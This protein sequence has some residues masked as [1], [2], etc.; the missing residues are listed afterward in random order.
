MSKK[1]TPGSVYKQTL[2]FIHGWGM[3]KGIWNPL[4]KQIP[5]GFDII[6]LSLPGYAETP[7][8]R[9]VYSIESIAQQL[10]EVLKNK[11]NMIVIGWSLGGL[12]SI[13]MAEILGEKIKSLIL[14]ASSPCFV[15]RKGWQLAVSEQVFKDF[16]TL[17]IDNID[18]TISRFIAIQLLG[19]DISKESRKMM[20]SSVKAYP[21]PEITILI[22]GLDILL[23]TD[24]REKLINLKQTIS[25]IGGSHDTLVPKAALSLLSEQ[26]S[27]QLYLI[28]KAGHAPFVS[29]QQQFLSSLLEVV[30]AC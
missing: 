11:N 2:V 5:K 15:Q 26:C 23:S 7:F 28:D 25:F 29:H 30:E 1:I 22:G 19:S 24:Y 21:N 10:S 12:V 16:M 27:A 20:I 9:A 4:I 17:L 6:C 18:K 8:D 13:R 14:V 3:N